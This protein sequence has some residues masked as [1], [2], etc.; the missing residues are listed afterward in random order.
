MEKIQHSDVTIYL[1]EV[2]KARR[3]YLGLCKKISDK[4]DYS[5]TVEKILDKSFKK[6]EYEQSDL[7]MERFEDVDDLFMNRL[8]KFYSKV[9]EDFITTH[10]DIS[11][12]VIEYYLT[13]KMMR[14]IYEIVYGVYLILA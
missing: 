11:P 1:K 10:P 4:P 8:P 5:W 6:F 13:L 9:N 14:K 12:T 3:R 7:I 2:Q